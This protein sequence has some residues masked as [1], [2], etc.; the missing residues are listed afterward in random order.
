MRRVPVA[1]GGVRQAGVVGILVGV[2]TGSSIE[3]AGEKPHFSQKTREM[4]HPAR[5]GIC[6]L[7]VDRVG[8]QECP[9][10]ISSPRE[11]TSVEIMQ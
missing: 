2:G 4:G 7:Y 5:T 10:H 11:T 1:V 9:P 3:G 6:D 8:G